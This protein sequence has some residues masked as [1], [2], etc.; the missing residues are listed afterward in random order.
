MV[1]VFDFSQLILYDMYAGFS[2]VKLTS[3]RLTDAEQ[4]QTNPMQQ[5]DVTCIVF[6]FDFIPLSLPD[7]I[8]SLSFCLKGPHYRDVMYQV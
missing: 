4:K 5:N 7:E 8:I 2:S 6:F 3:F 1:C